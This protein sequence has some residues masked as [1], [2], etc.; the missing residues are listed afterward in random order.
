MAFIVPRN[1]DVAKL[2]WSGLTPHSKEAKTRSH[3]DHLVGKAGAGLIS[4]LTALPA[5]M[6]FAV[7]RILVTVKH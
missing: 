5:R 1:D 6:M 3:G 2:A 7:T 4:L